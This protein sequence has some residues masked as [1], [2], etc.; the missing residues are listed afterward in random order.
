MFGKYNGF[1]SK[2]RVSACMYFLVKYY[3]S[4]LISH[5]K[6]V[7]TIQDRQVQYCMTHNIPDWR[8]G[9]CRTFAKGLFFSN[10]LF[11]MVSFCS[12]SP[13]ASLFS[14]LSSSSKQV[15]GAN[16]VNICCLSKTSQE[17]QHLP[18]LFVDKLKLSGTPWSG[19]R[20][21]LQSMLIAFFVVLLTSFPNWAG[22]LYFVPA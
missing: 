11:T 17:L 9:D 15:A 22:S 2:A 3:L 14:L 6:C 13:V 12:S 21:I 4:D 10:K 20:E 8:N 19:V 1:V 5:R 18:T 7:T 16:S